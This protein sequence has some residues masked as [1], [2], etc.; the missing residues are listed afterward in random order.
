MAAV[1]LQP[2]QIVLDYSSARP[3]PDQMVAAG[4]KA[5]CRYI[6]G[7]NN[8]TRP[9]ILTVAERDRLWNAGLAIILNWEQDAGGALQGGTVGKIHGTNAADM[10]AGLDYPKDLPIAVSV[11]VGVS[12]NQLP[13]VADYFYQFKAACPW[14]LTVY[15]GTFVGDYLVGAGFADG[16]WQASASSWSPR[17]SE[18]VFLKQ[19]YGAHHTE[20]VRW[21]AVGQTDDNT[22]IAPF[23]A[24]FPTD[25]SVD[26][27][28]PPKGKTM[29]Y[30]VMRSDGAQFIVDDRLELNHL[31]D[32]RAR[33]CD[34]PAPGGTGPR[35]P[36]E[37]GWSD[38]DINAWWAES[39]ANRAA[40]QPT[41]V[42]PQLPPPPPVTV[43]LA[44]YGLVFTKVK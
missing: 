43:D 23:R 15:G 20:T 18:H 17:P 34:S 4:V 6:A 8:L 26:L 9:K 25:V 42:N 13:A 44:E 41:V 31:S 2:G 7:M 11:D 35:V 27:V 30:R 14:P 36:L 33:F 10:A 22:V 21:T 28:T 39:E 29:P 16:I 5:V 37:Q 1:T 40:R 24:W 32:V 38:A 12:A 19:H 3:D